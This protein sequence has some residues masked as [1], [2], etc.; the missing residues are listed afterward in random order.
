MKSPFNNLSTLLPEVDY[1]SLMAQMPQVSHPRRKLKE[2][3]E[4]GLLIRLK[5]G[6]YIL[7]KELIGK[8]YSPEIAANLIYGPSYLSL[9]YALSF[10]HLIPERVEHFT[11]VTTQKNKRYATPLGHFT[12][13]HLSTSLYP[14][15]V[16][17]KKTSEGRYFMIATQE[18]ALMDIFTLKF[19]NSIR[20]QPKDIPIALEEDLR[21][22][23]NEM[24]TQINKN[25]LQNMKPHY[26]GRRWNKLAIDF[27]LENL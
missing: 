19:K 15:G 25:L 14:L 9:E 20:P 26:R 17:L 6:F 27:I 3:Q 13:Q 7:S 18:K 24:K 1:Q 21:I 2:L 10:Y 5:K 12:Y 4:K 16:T 11:S 23:L 8:D 22:D